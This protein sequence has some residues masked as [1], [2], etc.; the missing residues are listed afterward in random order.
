MA[1]AATGARLAGRVA[2][3]TGGASGIGKAIAERLVAD[4][5]RVAVADLDLGRTRAVTDRLGANAMAIAAD[6]ADE[7]SVD[8]LVAA[9]VERFGSLDVMV[10]NAG[11]IAISPLIDTGLD[12]WRRVF[13]SN[14]EG[15]F[16]CCRAAA[17]QMIAQGRGGT[18]INASSGA[19]RR[20]GRYVSH[21][22]A[23]KAAV[24][25][26]TQSLALELAPHRIRANCYAPGHI[27]TPMW[28]EIAK[29]IGALDGKPAEAV[30]A[31][32]AASI[33][34]GHFGTPEDV[35][36]TV[37]FLASDDAEYISGQTIAMNG[38]ELFF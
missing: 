4:G 35:A 25:L 12:E 2:I 36:A 5:A 38:A 37:S 19:G 17:R 28:D 20:G 13:R 29:R 21:Y 15:V 16:I 7:A 11:T 22:C 1:T 34:W 14:V 23:S 31:N 3:V 9:T 32:V 6:V 18:I 26:M 33:P 8:S 30:R 10:N 27:E 24:I